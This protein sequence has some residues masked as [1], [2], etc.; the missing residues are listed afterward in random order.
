MKIL[1]NQES[2][3]KAIPDS[4]KNF[5]LYDEDNYMELSPKRF[6]DTTISVNKYRTSETAQYYAKKFPDKKISVLNFTSKTNIGS[7][8]IKGSSAQ[9]E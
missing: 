7:G 3:K 4:I 8:V 5:V 1:Q 6:D 2:L 9:E